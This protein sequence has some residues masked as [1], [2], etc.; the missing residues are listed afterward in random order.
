MLVNSIPQTV[1]NY[2]MVSATVVV[3][4]LGLTDGFYNPLRMG[5]QDRIDNYSNYI[6]AG[7]VVATRNSLKAVK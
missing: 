6:K 5:Q 1:R 3:M 2:V 4:S 7:M